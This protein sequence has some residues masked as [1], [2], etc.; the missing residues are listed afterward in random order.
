MAEYTAE[1]QADLESEEQPE[2]GNKTSKVL[3]TILELAIAFALAVGLTW[4]L[5]T[6]VVEPFEVPTGSMETTIMIDDKLLAEKV[7][8]NFNAVERGDIVVFADKVVPGRVLVKR[9]IATGG[10]V[11]DFNNGH[12]L[13][14]G[15]PLYEPYVNGAMTYPL[16]QHFENTIIDYPFTVPEGHIWVMGDN[17]ENSADSRYFGSITETSIYGR[18][19]MVFWP[20]ENIGPL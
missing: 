20:L 12:V 13:V 11:V 18:A 1:D 10:Q 19:I 9:V 2:K 5:R 8:L 6:F 15:V 7:S 3:R 17:R 14:D 4:L 16:D